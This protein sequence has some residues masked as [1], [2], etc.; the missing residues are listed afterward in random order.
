MDL[1]EL[2]ELELLSTSDLQKLFDKVQNLL[3][4]AE[5]DTKDEAF[6]QT[7][8]FISV[9][10]MILAAR[11]HVDLILRKMGKNDEDA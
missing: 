5:Y 10:T 8:E 1:P 6:V 4:G 7:A 3:L 9:I 11:E 2:E